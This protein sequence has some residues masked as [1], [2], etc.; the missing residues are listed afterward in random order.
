MYIEVKNERNETILYLH[1]KNNKVD[2]VEL[3]KT[4]DKEKIVNIKVNHGLV[5]YGKILI[6]K[7]VMRSLQK[8]QKN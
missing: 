7:F 8:Y 6:R 3:I 2:I 5:I 1:V 4:L